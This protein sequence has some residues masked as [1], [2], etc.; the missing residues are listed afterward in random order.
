[1]TWVN[2]CADTRRPT[3]ARLVLLKQAQI[4]VFAAVIFYSATRAVHEVAETV[5][6]GMCMDSVHSVSA[7][8]PAPCRMR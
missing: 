7:A 5:Y 6:E 3:C 2:T 8:A 4:E 1:L